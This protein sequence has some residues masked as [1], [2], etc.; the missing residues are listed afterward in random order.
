[1]FHCNKCEED[2]EL[3][4]MVMNFSKRK[5]TYYIQKICKECKASYGK[6]YKKL[7]KESILKQQREYKRDHK[8]EIKKQRKIYYDKNKEKIKEYKKRNPHVT[9]KARNNY[10]KKNKEN[11]IRYENFSKR[12][13]RCLFKNSDKHDRLIDCSPNYFRK[14]IQYQ[15]IG[16]MNM[17][18]YGK[19]WEI[20]HVIPQKIL[21][22]ES[23]HWSNIRPCYC[24]ENKV[25]QDKIILYENVLQELKVN[26]Y[27]GFLLPPGRNF[28]KGTRLIT[29]PNSKKEIHRDNPQPSS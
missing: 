12:I 19:L 5:Q 28:W 18:N 7:N 15:F 16:D 20:D 8:E 25:K 10:Y 14:W 22:K 13:R 3:K 11:I 1:M 27:C 23:H 26:N 9:K 4:N 24:S 21:D 17:S 6:R 29:V 2:K